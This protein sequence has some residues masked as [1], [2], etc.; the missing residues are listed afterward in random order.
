MGHSPRYVRYSGERTRDAQAHPDVAIGHVDPMGR[1]D[2]NEEG[3]ASEEEGRLKRRP[4]WRSCSQG[5]APVGR[6]CL[7]T[8]AIRASSYRHGGGTGPS[9]VVYCPTDLDIRQGQER[10]AALSMF[11]SSSVLSQVN[12]YRLEWRPGG[13]VWASNSCRRHVRPSNQSCQAYTIGQIRF[14]DLYNVVPET[15][16]SLATNPRTD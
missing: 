3:V 8:D 15:P 16:W 2:V 5:A 13:R 1:V 10:F 12:A 7:K 9:Q 6:P 4:A 11:Q 14:V